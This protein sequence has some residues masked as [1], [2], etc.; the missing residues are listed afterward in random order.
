MFTVRA[1]NGGV[2]IGQNKNAIKEPS[3]EEKYM[4]DR[5]YAVWKYMTIAVTLIAVG[6]YALP[7]MWY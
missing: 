5:E 2:I 1:G 4:L 7:M 6:V 3:D